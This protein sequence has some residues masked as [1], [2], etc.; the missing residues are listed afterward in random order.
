MDTQKALLERLLDEYDGNIEAINRD[1]HA[2]RA[3]RERAARG[4]VCY[5]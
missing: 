5:S 2:L 3:E 4:G 1:A